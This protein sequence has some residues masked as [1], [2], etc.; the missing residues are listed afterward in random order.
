MSKFNDFLE[1]MQKT[2]KGN[3][4]SKSDLT[5]LATEMFND[6]D[7]EIPVFTKRGDSFDK[8]IHK[9]GAALRTN[10]IAPILKSFGVDRAEMAKLAEVQTSRAGGEALADFGL[11]M[12]KYYISANGLGRKLTLP[13]TSPDEAVQ[14]ISCI[15]AD[16][17]KRA[18]TMIVRNE[19]GTYSTAPTGKVV[20]TKAH[21]KVKVGNR[22]PAWLK[23]TIDAK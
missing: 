21:E 7:A 11:L 9:P 23:Q 19:D 22:V 13:M 15:K 18:T 1:T 14:S 12:M 4:Y 16:E 6:N 10:L 20:T 5:S 17:E 8:K 2:S 3:N